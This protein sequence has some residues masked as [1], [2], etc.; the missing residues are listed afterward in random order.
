M[1]FDGTLSPRGGALQPDHDAPGNGLAFKEADAEQ[2]R[3]A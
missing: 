3:I 1:L 2:Y